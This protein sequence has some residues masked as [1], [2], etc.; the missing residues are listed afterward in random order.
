MSEETTTL[1]SGIANG[2]KKRRR[3]LI[4]A[5]RKIDDTSFFRNAQF[6]LK[7]FWEQ[8]DHNGN[9]SKLFPDVFCVRNVTPFI[10]A[11]DQTEFLERATID[12]NPIYKPID[13]KSPVPLSGMMIASYPIT[14]CEILFPDLINPRYELRFTSPQMINRKKGA[15]SDIEILITR[16]EEKGETVVEISANCYELGK[17]W[18]QDI[19]Q[20]DVR[21]RGNVF[22]GIKGKLPQANDEDSKVYIPLEDELFSTFYESRSFN[23]DYIA[24]RLGQLKT[25]GYLLTL[26]AGRI[27]QAAKDNGLKAIYGMQV[28]TFR[29][30]GISAN[31]INFGVHFNSQKAE[32]F[33]KEKRKYL[34]PSTLIK[35]GDY[36]IASGEATMVR[37]KK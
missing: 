3:K 21:K 22:V 17:N 12:Y 23:T 35:T 10:S 24:E 26:L 9:I 30:Q 37:P 36:T 19:A 20:I 5:K 11:E 31:S 33:K 34:R 29:G 7:Q 4:R 27:H 25:R 14:L 18:S 6:I 2:S 1:G 28:L 32:N 15:A 16:Y 8:N 13:D